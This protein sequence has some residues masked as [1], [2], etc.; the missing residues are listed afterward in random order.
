MSNSAVIIT[1]EIKKYYGSSLA[2]ENISFEIQKGEIIGFLGHNGAGKTTLMRIL[3][4]YLPASSGECSI[5]G[6]DIRKHSLEIRK[7]IGYLPENP[8]LYP[9]MTVMDYLKF[10]AELKDVANRYVKA[11]T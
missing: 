10:A 2:L 1:K 3:T 5:G 6:F 4:S 9:S 7:M 8:P 11:Q